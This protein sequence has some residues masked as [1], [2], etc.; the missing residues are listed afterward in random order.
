MPSYYNHSKSQNSEIGAVSESSDAPAGNRKEYLMLKVKIAKTMT[1][2]T[3]L[4]IAEELDTTVS[5]VDQLW[6]EVRE[7]DE[8]EVEEQVPKEIQKQV[9]QYDLMNVELWEA[10]MDSKKDVEEET[11]TTGETGKGP[12]DSY[13]RK[14]AGR[15]PD[16]R[17]M[18]AIRAN[19]EAKARLL[20]ITKHLEFTLNQ[21]NNFNVLAGDEVPLVPPEHDQFTKKPAELPEADFTS[22]EDDDEE[23]PN[24]ELDPSGPQGIDAPE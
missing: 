16:P 1:G 19:N 23:D 8:F 22:I 20:G 14:V 11:T 12:I 10:W 18:D 9:H 24:T 3:R 5:Y 15:L 6:K 17:Y 13:K 2:K 4:Q 7:S 21:Q